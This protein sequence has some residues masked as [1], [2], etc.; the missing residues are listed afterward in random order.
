MKEEFQSLARICIISTTLNAGISTTLNAGSRA[1]KQTLCSLISY[2]L[3]DVLKKFFA[4][5]TFTQW[6]KIVDFNAKH[7]SAELT[8]CK[9]ARAGGFAQLILSFF[10]YR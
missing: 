9:S 2:L 5:A 3:F 10:H 6:S 4:Y 1:A 8:D 7:Y